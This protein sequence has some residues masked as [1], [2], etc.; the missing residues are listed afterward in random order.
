MTKDYS[1]TALWLDKWLIETFKISTDSVIYF[2]LPIQVIGLL[3]IAYLA[4][5]LTTKIVVASV[6]R[7]F[8]K[9]K[10]TW[11][12][13]LI[14][15]KVFDKLASVVPFG[16]IALSVPYI[17]YDFP[18]IIKYTV[19]FSDAAIIAVVIWSINATLTVIEDVLG[20]SQIFKDKPITS[21]VQVL[22]IIVYFI[23]A[24]LILSILLGKS[25]LYFLG[26]M[27]A[28]TAVLLLVF[29]DTILGLV[30]SIQ[31]SV[32]DMVRVGDWISMP[33]YEADGDV[34]SINL[35]TVKVQNWD[36]TITTIPTYAFITDSFKNWRG[37]SD[38]G[39]RRIKRSVNFK[40][41]SFK[42]LQKEDIQQLKHYRL[43]K[44]YLEKKE[45]EIHQHNETVH[46]DENGA[47]RNIR[48]LSNIGVFRHYIEQYIQSNENI[49]K[50]MT[51]MVR[52]LEPTSKGLPLEIY[53]FSAV[54]D[55]LPYENII[56]DIF[57][58]V[59][60]IASEFHLEIF[61]EPSGSDFQ[62]FMN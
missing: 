18:E 2:K 26:A 57:D 28:M 60:T 45:I 37:M 49:K 23:G 5:I 35:N 39:G 16:I 56:A 24:I 31:M 27:G 59:I 30:A 62:K 8:L 33:K 19:I 25:P 38:S 41:S 22:K 15:R 14:E 11:D 6:H 7:L 12:D 34:I 40:M 10:S 1:M 20:E 44:A 51:I 53:C 52:Q 58:H 46:N 32:Y 54:Q 13:L 43:I 61:E 42:F 17:F 29:K 48:R 50:D 9:T 21:Y 3:L 4:W 36:K 55:W 47:I